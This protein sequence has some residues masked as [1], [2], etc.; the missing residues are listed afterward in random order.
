MT[1]LFRLLI[2]IAALALCACSA[3]IA[4]EPVGAQAEAVGSECFLFPASS[5]A[6][7]PIPG[8]GTNNGTRVE[9]RIANG[10]DLACASQSQVEIFKNGV[11]AGAGTVFNNAVLN[12]TDFSVTPYAPSILRRQDFLNVAKPCQYKIWIK[13]RSTPSSG[14]DWRSFGPHWC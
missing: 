2:T 11:L 8:P 5:Q 6:F 14:N 3:E 13:Y 12:P 1:K 10:G 9:Y 7:N 4:D